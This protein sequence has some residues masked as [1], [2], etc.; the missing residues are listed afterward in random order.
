MAAGPL[1]GDAIALGANAADGDV[2]HVG[3]VHGDEGADPVLVR[4]LLEQVPHTAQVARTFLADIGDEQQIGAGTHTGGVHGAQ[5]REQHGEGAG[6]VADAGC[7]EPRSLAPDREVGA[8]GEYGVEMG[9]DADQWAVAHSGAHTG[10]VAFGVDLQVL[11]AVRLGHRQK[12][13]GAGFLLER[14]G[15]DLGECDDVIDRAIVLGGQGDDSSAVRLAGHDL[16]D[17]RH[18]MIGHG[19]RFPSADTRYWPRP[20][21]SAREG[22]TWIL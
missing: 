22:R 12:R 3:A 1:E 10:D 6:V 9:S 4:T 18:G 5:P 13:A 15:G 11:Q 14:R 17:S 20:T 16:T 7:V 19:I 8:G 2:V 21:P